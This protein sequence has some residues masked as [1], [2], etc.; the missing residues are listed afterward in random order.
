MHR[1]DIH[2]GFA[3]LNKLHSQNLWKQWTDGK[4]DDGFW[5]AIIEKLTV[6]DDLFNPELSDVTQM[7]RSA[8]KNNAT[9]KNQPKK[10]NTR[11]RRK[12]LK[13][14]APEE[15]R[16]DDSDLKDLIEELKT[17]ENINRLPTLEKPEC[18]KIAIIDLPDGSKITYESS[19][20]PE[21]ELEIQK[22]VE[23]DK[24]KRNM[25]KNTQ[26]KVKNRTENR[27]SRTKQSNKGVNGIT[28]IMP[29]YNNVGVLMDIDSASRKGIKKVK[30]ARVVEVTPDGE[31][32][33]VIE[34]INYERHMERKPPVSD[35]TAD[36]VDVQIEDEL[37]GSSH[38]NT[39]R[40]H[41]KQ[42]RIVQERDPR[43]MELISVGNL[44]PNLETQKHPE[45]G[46]VSARS[47]VQEA[48]Q[49]PEIR[50]TTMLGK[51]I[52]GTDSSHPL[53]SLLLQRTEA[54]EQAFCADTF[55]K[56]MRMHALVDVL[57]L[58]AIHSHTIEPGPGERQCINGITCEG[59]FT[60][61][62]DPIVL[63][64]YLTQNEIMVRIINN[65]RYENPRANQCFLCILKFANQAAFA[66]GAG[67][68]T[69]DPRICVSPFRMV[70]G[71]E[72]DLSRY[73]CIYP[74]NNG[75]FGPLLIHR[76]DSMESTTVLVNGTPR[77]ALR[78]KLSKVQNDNRV[79][80]QMESGRL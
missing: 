1:K 73:D 29:N 54:R 30:G 71:A 9:E 74:N 18:G 22:K 77:R 56:Q 35:I 27:N 11:G 79:H 6:C 36:G 41:W 47:F 3:R 59:M 10:S 51:Y 33:D 76:R 53:I 14:D 19:K 43:V 49:P 34:E 50:T 58:D 37:N 62:R 63:K 26:R 46:K 78:Y 2:N 39:S 72:N 61:V 44:N 68:S 13:E 40:L 64:E 25:V 57:T 66:I 4:V 70:P 20:N 15:A 45:K 21:K 12:R 28:P 32:I 38:S 24:E 52:S 65:G 48:S 17:H 5:K 80:F 55:E 67:T 31:T 60:Q 23:A 8:T 7:P 16:F 75:L 42:N 69:V